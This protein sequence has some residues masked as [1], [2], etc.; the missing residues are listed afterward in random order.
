[1]DGGDDKIKGLQDL[2]GV[3][4]GAV[5]QDVRFHPPEQGKIGMFPPPGLHLLFLP[6]Q[7]RRFQPPGVIGRLAVVREPQ[8]APAP[9][10][11]GGDQLLQ[12]IDPVAVV[13]VDVEA[14]PDILGGNEAG[15]AVL[16]PGLDLPQALPQLRAGSGAIPG[17]G[18][19][20]PL[21]GR[22]GVR[23][24]PTIPGG[25]APGDAPGPGPARPGSGRR[26]PWPRARR[27]RTP[28]ARPGSA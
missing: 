5:A 26:C 19:C 17:A 28:R 24:R 6:L 14:A 2:I 13:G 12:G 7:V 22:A 27:P 9:L 25:S 18:K 8:V 1:M 4:Q 11:G 16:P 10:F 20:R 23:R 15:Q 3:I 21:P